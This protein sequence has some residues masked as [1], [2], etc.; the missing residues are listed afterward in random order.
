MILIDKRINLHLIGSL[1]SNWS[2]F[3][4]LA[5]TNIPNS[6][7]I[8]P[9][10]SKSY[11][12]F[13]V[14]RE[15]HWLN[16]FLMECKSAHQLLGLNIIQEYYGISV[17]ICW[18]F[19]NSD[20]LF[21]Y[22]SSDARKLNCRI[23]KHCLLSC[24]SIFNNKLVIEGKICKSGWYVPHNIIMNTSES[25]VAANK[26][27]L[28][29]HWLWFSSCETHKA[30]CLW[31]NW[32]AIG[33]VIISKLSICSRL[34]HN[35]WWLKEIVII[36]FDSTLFNRFELWNDEGVFAHL[37][38]ECLLGL[39]S[40][41]NPFEQAL[42]LFFWGWRCRHILPWEV[43]LLVIWLNITVE[44][45]NEYTIFVSNTKYL[46]IVSGVKGQCIDWICVTNE[47]L[48]IVW[49][50]LLSLIV[51]DFNHVILATWYDIS[52]II[53]NSDLINGSSMTVC[54]LSQEDPFIFN[55]AIKS[56]FAIFSN[57]QK[58]S[59]IISKFERFYDIVDHDLMLDEE[60]VRVVD[61]HVVAV[62]THDSEFLVR[63]IWFAWKP[64]WKSNVHKFWW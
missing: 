31:I 58:I 14:I 22:G 38:P 55:Q 11:Q 6:K 53:G 63:I 26:L 8:V 18:A 49:D 37:V 50:R 2:T 15:T 43:S 56:Y 30:W 62:F 46:S 54:D 47:A 48:E 59:V 19:T 3:N 28:K 21:V 29:G 1:I 7:G 51:P 52:R 34:L 61:D 32:L 45:P 64:F 33:I 17:W 39:I 25:V 10:S 57:H 40:C 5:W 60:W 13:G 35:I 24:F 16:S 36:Y 4:N 23:S 12:I 20:I 44:F 41:S 42:W 27:L 9:L